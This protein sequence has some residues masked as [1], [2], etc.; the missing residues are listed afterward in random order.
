ME[1][2]L[3]INDRILVDEITPRFGGYEHGDIVVFQDPG[4]WL[5]PSTRARASADHR[6]HRLGAV[7]SSGCRPPTATT[8][9]SSASSG[10]RATTSSAATRSGRSRSTTSRSTRP[11]YVKLP[12]GETAVSADPFDVIGPR[13]QP[14][15]ARRQPVPIQGLPLQHRPARRGLRADRER[16]RPRVRDHLAAQPVRR[17]STS[18]TTCSPA[19][20]SPSR[21]TPRRDRRGAPPDARATAPAGA[22]DRHR[23][24]RG[25]ARCAGRP[26]RGRRGRHRRA[27]GAQA[28]SA[29]PARLEARPRAARAEVAARAASWVSASAVGW[30]SSAEID[31]VGIMRALGLATIRALADLRAHGVVPEEA[32]VHPR[33]QLRLHHRRP[34]RAGSR[35][36]R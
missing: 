2:T 13:G 36:G 29:G 31:E 24:R 25:G 27:A 21:R 3:L 11:T 5:P 14:V 16:R 30:A 22:S 32:I 9:S 23:V 10:C 20:P 15:G 28:G 18:T 12:S 8:T 35:C 6:G 1:D 4:G 33:R 7:A 26:G 34:A 17:C 19:S